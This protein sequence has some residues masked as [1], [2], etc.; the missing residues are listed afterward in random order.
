MHEIHKHTREID[1]SWMYTTNSEIKFKTNMLKSSLYDFSDGYILN[2]G[3]IT[4]PNTKDIDVN[5]SN[6]NKKVKLKGCDYI[7]V[8]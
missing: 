7:L 8:A 1:A 4:V 5:A 6:T 2:K 3:T